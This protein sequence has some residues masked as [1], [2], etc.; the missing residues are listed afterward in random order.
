[1]K[2]LNNA[3]EL[4]NE[5]VAKQ[6]DSRDAIPTPCGRGSGCVSEASYN[7]RGGVV[8]RHCEEQSDEAIHLTPHPV[9]TLLPS[10]T[11]GEGVCHSNSGNSQSLIKVKHLFAYSPIRLFTRKCKAFTLAEVLI[12]LAVIG[13][14]AVMTIPNL[15]QNYQNKAWNTADTVFQRKLTEAMK[16]MNTQ[17]TLAG[18]TKTE[19]F[20]QELSKHLKITRICDNTNLKACFEEKISINDKI[21]NISEVKTAEDFGQIHWGTNVVGFQL[22]NGVNGLMAYNPECKQDQYSNQI[23]GSDCLAV[24]YDVSGYTSPNT[25]QKDLRVNGNV[26]KINGEL[27]CLIKLNG[28]CYSVPFQPSPL[29]YAECMELVNSGVIEA[30]YVYNR[31][32]YWAG[33]VKTCGGIDNMTSLYDLARLADYIYD[34]KNTGDSRGSAFVAKNVVKKD[35][36]DSFNNGMKFRIWSSFENS[37][38]IGANYRY[39]EPNR[40]Y[41]Q[42]AFRSNSGIFGMCKN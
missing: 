15:V 16:M 18:Y 29:K 30:C 17:G 3:K 11:R 9:A 24:V 23:S 35:F 36:Y 6:N 2:T 32:D 31:A 8:T 40:T 22:A 14:V 26:I 4:V 38:T 27:V 20:V 21:I 37:N 41:W 19:D 7:H 1:M 5:D 12:T 33:T 25:I 13:I 28:V 39:F 42:D 10:P 34:V